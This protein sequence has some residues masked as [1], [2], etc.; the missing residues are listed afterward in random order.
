MPWRSSI[1]GTSNA[2][3]Y[4][5][6]PSRSVVLRCGSTTWE[7]QA[8]LTAR[9]LQTAA[10]ERAASKLNQLG[11]ERGTLTRHIKAP[12]EDNTGM[13]A[14]PAPVDPIFPR[15]LKEE[16]DIE[17]K[18]IGFIAYGLYEEAKREWVSEFNTKEGRYPSQNELQ[19]YENT[20]TASRIESIRNS[21]AQAVSAYAETITA[22]AE[23]DVLH[24]S[25]RGTLWR[26]I[27]RWILSACIFT[28]GIVGLYILCRRTGL[29]LINLIDQLATPHP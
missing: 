24:R 22:Q 14:D 2:I 6:P 4:G 27:W 11:F 26:T 10:L 25:L 3:G 12:M 21:A 9:A 15:L 19:A 7:S 20:W 13:P 23:T 5:F 28:L 8:P 1:R 29:D 16:G 17:S 18:L